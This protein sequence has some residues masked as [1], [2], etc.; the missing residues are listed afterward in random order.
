M[1]GVHCVDDLKVWPVVVWYVVIS[2]LYVGVYAGAV[3]YAQFFAQNLS[4]AGSASGVVIVW[5]PAAGVALAFCLWCGPTCFPVLW[6]AELLTQMVLLP[7]GLSDSA[8][9]VWS[10][11]KSLC[12]LL[13][14]CVLL[15]IEPNVPLNVPLKALRFLVIVIVFH[16]IIGSIFALTVHLSGV[17][18]VYSELIYTWI[19]GDVTGVVSVTVLFIECRH[20]LQRVSL[21][22]CHSVRHWLRVGLAVKWILLAASFA[23]AIWLTFYPQR[24]SGPREYLMLLPLLLAGLLFGV[25]G[26]S[27]WTLVL[28]VVSITMIRYVP[29]ILGVLA[30]ADFQ[31]ALFVFATAAL[32]L[33]SERERSK[34][35]AR[36]CAEA[37][38]LDQ[39]RKDRNGLLEVVAHDI[40]TPLYGISGMLDSLYH[41]PDLGSRHRRCVA[42]AKQS[43]SVLSAIVR[44][45][46]ALRLLEETGLVPVLPVLIS[47]RDITRVLEDTV[48]LFYSTAHDGGLE[49]SCKYSLRAWKSTVRV[50]LAD[51]VRLQQVLTNLVSNALKFTTEGNLKFFFFFWMFLGGIKSR[52]E[53]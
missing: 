23:L 3:K 41:S 35:F 45:V 52:F 34:G 17:N 42:V 18:I 49:L 4:A 9:V 29:S 30:I 6:G 37:E 38:R 14:S 39:L 10:L 12:F 28:L 22:V 46:L 15:C 21:N 25:I 50:Q 8:N 40:K 27:F 13:E 1:C 44:D 53:I 24:V 20:K 31:L 19:L 33:A 2:M 51:L 48:N 36:K 47:E 5:F 16:F 26:S 7:T 43:C 11:I 32:F